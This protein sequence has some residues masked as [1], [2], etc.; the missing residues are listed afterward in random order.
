[1]KFKPLMDRVLAKLEE[2]EEKTVSGIIIP[3][4]AKEKP[5]KATVVEIG[6]DVELVKQGDTVL[7]EKYS[8][9]ELK[10]DDETYI[11][12]KEDEILGKFE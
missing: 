7:F 2:S 9:S 8:G 1:M 6:D 3:D 11:I 10:I 5:Q 12:L 4:T